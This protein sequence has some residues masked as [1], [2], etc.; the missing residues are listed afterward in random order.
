[1]D[2]LLQTML[3][4]LEDRR[5]LHVLLKKANTMVVFSS[6][7]KKWHLFLSNNEVHTHYTDKGTY[8]VSIIGEEDQLYEVIKG[9]VSLRQLQQMNKVHLQGNYRQILLLEA[10]LLLSNRKEAV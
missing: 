6:E 1:M 9:N 3:S 10:L 5:Q 7:H 4:T 2:Q 8:R